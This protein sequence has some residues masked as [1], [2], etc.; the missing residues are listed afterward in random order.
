M[1][2]ELVNK[3]PSF[4]KVCYETT[5]GKCSDN[6]YDIVVAIPYGKRAFLWLTHYQNKNICCI[7]ELDRNQKIQDNVTYLEWKYDNE[8]ALGTIVSGYI[9][10]HEDETIDQKYFLID[11]I[12]A[13]KGYKFGNPVPISFNYKFNTLKTFLQD[14][15]TENKNMNFSFHSICM[16]SNEN[17]DIDNITN[18]N[19]SVKHIQYRC[20]HDILPSLNLMTK[21]NE[22]IDLVVPEIYES[23]KIIVPHYLLNLKKCIKD[24]MQIFIVKA[25]IS[26]DVYYLFAKDNQIFQY[27]FIPDYKTSVMMNGLFRNIPQNNN[28]DLIEQSDDEDTFQNT[29][30]YKYVNLKKEVIMECVFNYKF[31]K[32]VPIR[33][34]SYNYKK[35]VPEL[36]Q[37]IFKKNFSNNNIHVRQ[38]K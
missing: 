22:I 6:R 37:L 29:S 36:Q 1:N 8:F 16:F 38:R 32:W 13:Y 17:L 21:K 25:D 15:Y 35:F 14:I 5:T 28:I 3:F 10:D 18:V 19:Y 11:D 9:L 2:K 4:I 33:A 12:F 20:S 31:K 34:M 23:P 24:N 27:A 26:Y 7:L 30:K